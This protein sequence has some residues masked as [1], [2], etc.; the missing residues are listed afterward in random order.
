MNMKMQWLRNSLWFVVTLAIL[1]QSAGA[2]QFS[3]MPDGVS[4]VSVSTT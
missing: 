1:F 3:Q 4:T 2:R